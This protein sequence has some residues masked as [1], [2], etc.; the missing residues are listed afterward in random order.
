MGPPQSQSLG[1]QELELLRW[2]AQR[3]SVTAAE[4]AEGFGAPRKLARSTVVTMMERLR[5]KGY[6]NRIQRDGVYRYASPVG[7]EALLGGL[8][9]RFVEKT[10]AGS[11]SPLIAYFARAQRLS[12][13][14]LTQLEGLI[15]KLQANTPDDRPQ[16]D[17][18]ED[19]GTSRT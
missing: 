2:I 1:E 18:Q 11:L 9:Q 7:Q 6:L 4:V 15:H 17:K 8:V 5:K 19:P 13:E 12:P 16:K 14:E 3:G 10:L